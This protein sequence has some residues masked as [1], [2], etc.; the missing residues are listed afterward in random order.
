MR[1]PMWMSGDSV[2]LGTDE[3]EE[4]DEGIEIPDPVEDDE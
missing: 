1:D 4:L 3:E 2:A